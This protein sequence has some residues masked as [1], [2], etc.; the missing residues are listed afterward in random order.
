MQVKLQT[1][2][3]LHLCTDEKLYKL[4]VS[5]WCELIVFVV[6]GF[7]VMWDLPE[8][9]DMIRI[10]EEIYASGN[11]V[12]AVCHGPAALVGVKGPDGELLAK[13]AANPYICTGA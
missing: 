2:C 11:V 4:Y 5:C 3:F 1:R 9:K 13:V 7:G 10:A 12:S 6:G 8:D